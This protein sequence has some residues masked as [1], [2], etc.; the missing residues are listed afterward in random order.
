MCRKSAGRRYIQLPICSIEPRW[1]QPIAA[2]QVLDDHAKPN[3]A[4]CASIRSDTTI[5]TLSFFELCHQS[6]KA[7][8]IKAG[9]QARLCGWSDSPGPS[10]RVP[11]RRPEG[12]AELTFKLVRDLDLKLAVGAGVEVYHEECSLLLGFVRPS[13]PSLTG[14]CPPSPAAQ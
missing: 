6:A 12:L 2:Q 4:A 8:A 7:G 9:K 14:N 13:V 10:G 3:E 1:L 5:R 11:R